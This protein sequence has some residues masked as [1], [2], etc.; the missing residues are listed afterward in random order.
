MTIGNVEI[1][2]KTALAPMAGVTDHA[3]RTICRR[4]GASY[5]VTEMVSGKGLMYHDKKTAELLNCEGENPVAAQIFGSEPD[6][7]REAAVEA[8]KVSGAQVIDL[9]MGCPM[10]KITGNGEG[11]ALMLNPELAESIVRAI[12]DTISAPVTVKFRL[13]WDS[14]TA[15]DFARRMEA[16]GA[17][18]VCI[19]GRTREQYYGGKADWN[20][21][22]KVAKA[23]KI[24]V[25]VSGDVFSP[26]DAVQLMEIS[27]AALCMIGRASYGNPWIFERVEAALAGREV[28][29]EPEFSEKIALAREH[30][31]LSIAER[32]EKR[33]V[34]EA[35]HHISWYCKGIP[36]AAAMR[37]R[38]STLS[39]PE[40][41]YA[42][43][44]ELSEK[45]C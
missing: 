5:A 17:D 7:L 22:A 8:L 20:A 29:P 4:N 13:G 42:L 37:A 10:P 3:Y 16:A 28:P 6:V 26:D 14:F 2:G 23:V 21:M 30:M 32:G 41:M 31:A 1:R 9:N 45:Y 11:S 19:H 12:K 27:G 24:P 36:G 34:M 39:T 15:D 43:L 18:A 44:D 38:I 35:R 40:Q 25:I 33:A